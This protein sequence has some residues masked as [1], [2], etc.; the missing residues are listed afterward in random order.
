MYIIMGIDNFA[1]SSKEIKENCIL[2]ADYPRFTNPSNLVIRAI[3]KNYKSSVV[4]SIIDNITSEERFVMG[5]EFDLYYGAPG[6]YSSI[7]E[8]AINMIKAG[9][10]QKNI[11][12]VTKLLHYMEKDSGD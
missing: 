3:D 10:D 11:E 2:I 6:V 8:F 7:D 4:N 5:R 12:Q 1:N 9:R